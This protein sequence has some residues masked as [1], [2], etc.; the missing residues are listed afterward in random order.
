MKKEKMIIGKRKDGKRLVCVAM[1]AIMIASV[2]VTFAPAS[3]ADHPHPVPPGNTTTLYFHPDD[4]G[5]ADYSDKIVQVYVNTTAGITSGQLAILYDASCINITDWK[6]NTALWP[7]GGG[8]PV[9]PGLAFMTFLKAAPN[10][11]GD[12]LIGNLTIH[13][14]SRTCCRTDLLFGTHPGTGQPTKLSNATGNTVPH[15]QDNGTFTCGPLECLEEEKK[16]RGSGGS[17]GVPK[18]SQVTPQPQAS[19]SPSLPTATVTP[20]LISTPTPTATATSPA[21]ATPEREEEEKQ[22]VPGFDAPLAIAIIALLARLYKKEKYAPEE[23][24]TW[25]ESTK[26]LRRGEEKNGK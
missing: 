23:K 10:V 12:L 8:G 6:R 20:T 2:F 11:T 24:K 21:T 17:S 1:A 7:M 14:N 3:V 19:P 18:T 16:H 15:V 9:Y 26:G 5:S 22:Q 4:S 13:C 25:F